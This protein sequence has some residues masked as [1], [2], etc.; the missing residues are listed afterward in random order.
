[1]GYLKSNHVTDINLVEPLN[2]WADF[3]NS[4]FAAGSGDNPLKAI[5]R[6]DYIGDF[7]GREI[8]CALRGCLDPVLFGVSWGIHDH[9]R[10]FLWFNGVTR[11]PKI[12]LAGCPAMP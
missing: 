10:F 1:V 3:N 2:E 6:S 5:N 12:L 7:Y 11:P 4:G 9:A 8:G